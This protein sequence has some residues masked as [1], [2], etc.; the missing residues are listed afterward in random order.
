[1]LLNANLAYT[2]INYGCIIA[3]KQSATRTAARISALIFL[4]DNTYKPTFNLYCLLSY[5]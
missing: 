4:L 2:N 1:M 5:E 3:G